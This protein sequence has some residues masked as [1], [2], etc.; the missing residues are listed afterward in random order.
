MV[1]SANINGTARTELHNGCR[2]QRILSKD[3]DK[4][5]MAGEWA[6]GAFSGRFPDVSSRPNGDAGV[7]FII[8]LRYSVDVKTYRNPKRLPL[9]VGKPVADIVVLAGYDECT[10]SAELIGWT[11]GT[12]LKSAPIDDGGPNSIFR[13]GIRNH[14]IERGKLRPMSELMQRLGE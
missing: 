6:F 4:V 12:V 2:S 8:P 13:N 11:W 3:H 9:E 14:Y 7:D 10:E 1:N 5:G